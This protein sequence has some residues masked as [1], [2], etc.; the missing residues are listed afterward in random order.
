MRESRKESVLRKHPE[1]L[2]VRNSEIGQ[3]IKDH[4]L[5][6]LSVGLP[7]YML[8]GACL[9]TNFVLDGRDKQV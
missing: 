4:L 2:R 7:A 9:K 5:T 8:G 6:G 3:W 1:H